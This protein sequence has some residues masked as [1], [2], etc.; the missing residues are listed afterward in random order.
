MLLQA[1]ADPN[2]GDEFGETPLHYAAMEGHVALV[3]MLL[4]NRAIIEKADRHGRTP[5]MKVLLNTMVSTAGRPEEVIKP[6]WQQGLIK[7]KL[8]YQE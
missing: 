4:Q 5:L 2:K 3:E 1:G 6:D 8:R 7:S